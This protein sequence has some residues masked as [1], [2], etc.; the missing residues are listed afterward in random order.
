MANDR[1]VS[2]DGEEQ[3]PAGRKV[4]EVLLIQSFDPASQDYRT[5][6]V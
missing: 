5:T 4:K 6:Y 3:L 2:I 1:R